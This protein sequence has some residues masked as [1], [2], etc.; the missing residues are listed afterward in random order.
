M[1]QVL[2]VTG[3]VQRPLEPCEPLYVGSPLPWVGLH[4]TGQGLARV[5]CIE[6]VGGPLHTVQLPS[7]GC[8][9]VFAGLRVHR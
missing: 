2:S 3:R 9:T 6:Q 4:L 7:V 5:P 1:I 8:L